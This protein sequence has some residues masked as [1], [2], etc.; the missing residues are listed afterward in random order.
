LEVKIE[1]SAR[2]PGEVARQIVE[3]FVEMLGAVEGK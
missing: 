1:A 3:K 2:E